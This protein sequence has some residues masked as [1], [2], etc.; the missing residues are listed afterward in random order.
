MVYDKVEA[1]LRIISMRLKNLKT[2]SYDEI[3]D[4][5]KDRSSNYQIDFYS[6]HDII[7]DINYNCC[8][9]IKNNNTSK[10]ERYLLNDSDIESIYTNFMESLKRKEVNP[11]FQIFL[12][13]QG[14]N[15]L[16]CTIGNS[17]LI[18]PEELTEKLI[19]SNSEDNV[20]CISG[21]K[22]ISIPRKLLKLK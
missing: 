22:Q 19:A 13:Y 21:E 9:I 18:F 11:N 7:A 17:I 3:V 16:A 10:I 20:A 4:R 14:I 1:N 15:Q 5:L 12:N 2:I 6:K 8:D